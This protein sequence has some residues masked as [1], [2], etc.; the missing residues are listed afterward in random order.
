MPMA[1][2]TP[3]FDPAPRSRLLAR[4][5]SSRAQVALTLAVLGLFLAVA[6]GNIEIMLDVGRGRS[7][8]SSIAATPEFALLLAIGVLMAV[9]L[10]LLS[11]IGG[12]LLTFACM[13][14]VYWLGYETTRRPLVPMEFLLLVIL[15]LYVIHV[16]ASYFRE[17]H[18]KQEV[19]SLFGQYV[20]P[21]LAARLG[22]DPHA[23]DLEGEARELTVLF[24][25]VQDFTSHAERMEPRELTAL[26]NALLTPLTEVVHRHHGTIDKYMGD[27]MMAFWGAPLTDPHHAAH[28]VA[29]A[30]DMQD[31]VARLAVEFERHGW[32]ALTL[33]IGINTGIVNV[34]NMGSRYRM[35]YTAIGDAVN[36][37]SRLEALTRVFQVPIIVGE[38]TRKAFPAATYRELG[39]VQVKGKQELTRVYEAL[40][41][42]LDPESTA[43][44][45][46]ARHKHALAVS[47]PDDPLYGY[48]LER[49]GEF[50]ATPPAEHWRG[51]LR[52][53][54]K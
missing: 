48:Y 11:P 37:A 17:V 21:D 15:A 12:S 26:L 24:C 33:G 32:P 41:P 6:S 3:A 51:E 5:R 4:L 28:A 49:I 7:T 43:V 25:D 42:N 50:R 27:A 1:P 16:L 20:P 46:L 53:T 35:A 38:S 9:L 19:I 30:Y 29:A 39:L 36:L 8:L 54:V 52:F 47:R 40:R 18:K 34:G 2:P 23:L 14:P 22:R 13:L 45:R 44:A 31:A 10:P